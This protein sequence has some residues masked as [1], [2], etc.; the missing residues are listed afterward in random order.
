MEH[1]TE[2][3]TVAA[4]PNPFNPSTTISYTLPEAAAVHLDI[5]SVAGQKVATLVDGPMSAGTHSAVFDGAGLASGVY[6]YRLTAG[7]A[8]VN[9]KVTLVR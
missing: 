7:E 8:V 1:P 5:F 2:Y 4:Y 3:P 9:G 6:V